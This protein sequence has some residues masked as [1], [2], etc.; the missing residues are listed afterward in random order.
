MS[1]LTPELG[2]LFWMMISFGIVLLILARYG[3]PVILKAVE[4][5]KNYIE[6]SLVAA[7]EAQEELGKVVQTGERML[8]EA[9]RDQH[10][11]LKETTRLKEQLIEEARAAAA[12]ESEKML[13]L[14]RKKIEAEQE[15]ALRTIRSEV[16]TL[17][18]ELAERIL[19][20]KLGDEQEQMKMIDRLLDEVDISKS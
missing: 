2:L 11:I 7:R 19:R 13:A 16:S 5:R 6:A 9:R 4:K 3:F 8:A 10:A 17:S 20:E 1:L 15:E 12:A 18:V 14:A